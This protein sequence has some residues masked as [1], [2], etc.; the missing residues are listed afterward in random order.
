MSTI[1]PPLP[2]RPAPAPVRRRGWWQ[3]NWKWVLAL[4]VLGAILGVIC[5]AVFSVRAILHNSDVYADAVARARVEPQV[6]AVLGEPVDPGFLPLGNISVSTGGG[7]RA[8]LRT[9]LRGGHSEGRLLAVAERRDGRW[10][11]EMLTFE[12]DG[13]DDGLALVEPGTPVDPR[14]PARQ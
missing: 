4:V 6:V 3:R 12:A 9:P 7:G 2:L 1:S 13:M 14:P 10:R 8:D 11:Y 5:V